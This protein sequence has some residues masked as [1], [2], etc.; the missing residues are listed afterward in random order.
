MGLKLP[1]LTTQAPRRDSAPLSEAKQ[2][3]W[4]IRNKI[5]TMELC[6]T[7]PLIWWIRCKIRTTWRQTGEEVFRCIWRTRKTK[8]IIRQDGA[9][10][11]KNNRPF[12][13]TTKTRPKCR[14][15]HSISQSGIPFQTTDATRNTIWNSWSSAGNTQNSRDKW[16]QTDSTSW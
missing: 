16:T 6:K 14:T 1:N 5:W 2:I 9:V 3:S 11:I 13:W 12:L 7:L 4:F 10:L 15:P 8:R